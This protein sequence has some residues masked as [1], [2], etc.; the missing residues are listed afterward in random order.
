LISAIALTSNRRDLPAGARTVCQ[1][2]EPS[3]AGSPE[4]QAAHDLREDL[5]VESDDADGVRRRRD[6]NGWN[7]RIFSLLNCYGSKLRM[8]RD[9]SIAS[10]TQIGGN[11]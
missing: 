11:C 6:R 7:Y 10:T 3:C 2:V 4:G 9:G 8:A 1:T 5:I